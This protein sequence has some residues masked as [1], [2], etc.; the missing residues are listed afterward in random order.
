[1][2]LSHRVR[3]GGIRPSADSAS[4]LSAAWSPGW[5]SPSPPLGD[6]AGSRKPGSLARCAALPL[7]YDVTDRGSQGRWPQTG[8]V[9]AARCQRGPLDP[10]PE[11]RCNAHAPRVPRRQQAEPNLDA[12]ATTTRTLNRL[13][14]HDLEP[15]RFEDLVRQLIYD[16]RPW[17]TLEPVGR[18]GADDGVDIRG[19]EEIHQGGADASNIDGEED[20]AGPVED[21]VWVFQCKREKEI[22]PTKLRKIIAAFRDQQPGLHG[23]VLVAACDFSKQAHDAF[24]EEMVARGV[25]EFHLWGKSD[26]EDMLF[27]PKNDHLLFAYFGLSLQARRRSQRSLIRSVIATK[28]QIHSVFKDCYESE[29]RHVGQVFVVRNPNDQSYPDE[30]KEGARKGWLLCRF[31]GRDWPEGFEVLWRQYPGWVSRDGSWDAVIDA[32]LAKGSML[33]DVKSKRGWRDSDGGVEPAIAKAQDFCQRYL[34]DSERA[35]FEVGRFIPWDRI[36]GVDPHG[37]AFFPVPHVFAEFTDELGPFTSAAQEWL[38]P[39]SGFEWGAP[40]PTD[41]TRKAF[42]PVPIPTTPFPPGRGITR[43]LVEAPVAVSADVEAKLGEVLAKAAARGAVA[44]PVPSKESL[45]ATAADPRATKFSAWIESVVM[46][47]FSMF[48]SRLIAS[49]HEAWILPRVVP[50]IAS[51]RIELRVRM[52]EPLTHNPDYQREGRI[53]Y[54]LRSWG[55]IVLDCWPAESKDGVRGRQSRQ[56]TQQDPESIT[57]D[58]VQLEVISM[59][60]RLAADH[61]P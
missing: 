51:E 13:P 12:M 24:R 33:A 60:Q 16:L 5:P 20:D 45:A 14:F 2:A 38:A 46:P 58:Q 29:G 9:G 57:S 4:W 54:E 17:K 44:E 31:L 49:G 18:G 35:T 47:V 36:V 10:I 52:R 32:D 22:G 56:R 48:A 23:F 28:K 11:G 59:L 15:H 40:R 6:I 8:R 39:F 30:P 25:A 50:M 41:A 55:E 37:D 61:Y 21:Q 34:S 42:F 53:A 3:L 43:D 7:P 26:I 27:Q 1:M 19:I